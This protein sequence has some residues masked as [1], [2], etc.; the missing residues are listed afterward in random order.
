MEKNLLKRAENYI[1][2]HRRNSARRA[3]F[4][5]IAALVVFATTYTLII[6]AVTWDRTLICE[7]TEHVHSDECY[8]EVTVPEEKKLIR[9]IC[10]DETHEHTDECYEIIPEHTEKVLSCVL[11]EHT[12]SAACF[13]AP[14]S[15]PEEGYYCGY[16]EHTHNELCYAY[17]GSLMC[18]IPEH[19]HE[20]IC[21]SNPNADLVSAYFMDQQVKS[22]NLGDDWAENIIAVAESQLGVSESVSNFIIENGTE[23]G[24]SRYGGYYGVPY[25]DWCAMFASFCVES[26]GVKDFPITCNCD[27]WVKALSA[28][29]SDPGRIIYF[30]DPN[31]YIPVPGDLIF[32]DYDSFDENTSRVADHVGIVYEIVDATETSPATVRTIEGN[33]GDR[34]CFVEHYLEDDI[35]LGYG[36]LPKNPDQKEVITDNISTA[37]SEDASATIISDELPENAEVVL[38]Y[39]DL[40]ESKIGGFL[41][42][43]IS[44]RVNFVAACDIS[45]FADGEE[46]Q[47]ENDVEVILSNSGITLRKNERL[48]IAHIEVS[49]SDDGQPAVETAEALDVSNITEEG[50]IV[51]STDGFSTYLFY[52]YTVDFHSGEVVYSIPVGSSVKLSEL[53]EQLGVDRSIADVVNVEFSDDKLLTVDQ[54]EGDWLLNSLAPFSSDETLSITFNNN[55]VYVISVTDKEVE[56]PITLGNSSEKPTYASYITTSDSVTKDKLTVGTRAVTAYSDASTSQ[57]ESKLTGDSDDD[58]KLLADKSVIYGKDD[59]GAFTTYADKTFSVT[60]SA[61]AQDY[62][63]SENDRVKVPLDVVFVLDV[64]GSM[65]VNTISGTSMTRMEA[66]VNATNQ[67]MKTIMDD[68][69]ENRVGVVFFSSGGNKILELDHYTANSDNK[70]LTFYNPSGSNYE[71]WTAEG[72]KNSNKATV[73]RSGGKLASNGG[74]YTQYGI[75][76][77]NDMLSSVTDTAYSQKIRSDT[78]HE[79]T[80]TV[81]RQPIVILLS[82]G[83]P[84]HCTDEYK[85]VLNAKHYGNAAYQ[86]EDNNKGVLGYYTILSANY[87]KEQ[88]SKHYDNNA[89]FYTIGMGI[90][91]SGYESL[92]SGSVTSDSYKRTVLNPTAEN[93]EDQIS[94]GAKNFTVDSKKTWSTTSNILYQLIKKTYSGTTVSILATNRYSQLGQTYENVPVV[95]YDFKDLSYADGAR[96]GNLTENDLK[97]TFQEIISASCRTKSYGYMLNDGVLRFVDRIGDGME[98][99]SDPILRYNGINYP[100]TNKSVSGKVTTYTYNYQPSMIYAEGEKGPDKK[101]DLSKITVTVTVNDDKSQTVVMSVPEQCLPTYTP[102]Y[103]GGDWYYEQLPMRLIYQVGLSADAIADI[104]K[105]ANSKSATYYTNAWGTEENSINATASYGPS[106]EN[107]YYLETGSYTD[108][109][110]LKSENVSGTSDNSAKSVRSVTANVIDLTF[111]NNG[112][113][114]I[115]PKDEIE[116]EVTKV[117]AANVP[118]SVKTPVTVTLYQSK[119]GINATAVTDKTVELNST[120]SWKGSIKFIPEDEY[121]YYLAENATSGLVGTYTAG[122]TAKNSVNL[123]VNNTFVKA[124][125]IDD[126]VETDGLT[127]TNTRVASFEVTKMW[128]NEADKTDVTVRL[129]KVKDNVVTK[130]DESI[131]I[132]AAT[133]WKETMTFTPETGYTYYLV[134]DEVAGTLPRYSRNSVYSSDKLLIDSVSVSAIKVYPN[135]GDSLTDLPVSVVNSSG[136]LLPNS[137]GIGNYAL[138]AMGIV[139]LLGAGV[140]LIK[141]RKNDCGA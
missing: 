134:E 12:H 98:L 31:Q 125:K 2:Q 29:E 23:Y 50:D 19:T 84:T 100:N 60:L 75:A 54:T 121:T 90:A 4:T 88:I 33:R 96:F 106:P 32:F 119:D 48:G 57:I 34:V 99:I 108:S 120:N 8:S 124:V 80:V 55:E 20:R 113:L 130:C 1:K 114:V 104:G 133:S 66:V 95:G 132:N 116:A 27:R 85:N 25:G 43:D 5:V 83:E 22:L 16:I 76:L 36:K 21:Q 97:S 101:A 93:I 140:I 3:V 67:A 89:L 72:L 18:T 79:R 47:P 62:E 38:T 64:S 138:Y 46:W 40:S 136:A 128:V 56:P 71:V 11:E 73:T 129:Y 82:D 13:D 9:E 65:L 41:G 68:N 52:T 86:N 77:A 107:P 24:Y 59:Y 63:L 37:L 61:L 74:T 139:L 109:S 42:E 137:G 112:K 123:K 15:E 111:G 102:D 6:P 118:D 35:I 92:T 91:E 103:N 126:D 58:G 115:Q 39:Q 87:Y 28:E 70:Y 94:D 135:A 69:E 44:S 131:T 45:I 26:A 53:F 51:F 78:V 14:P 117:W 105:L 7:K 127:V 49:A 122:T 30:R 17:D 110:P 81:Q 141:K 10:D